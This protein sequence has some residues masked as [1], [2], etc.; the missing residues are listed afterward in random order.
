MR[1]RNP[2]IGFIGFGEAGFH[3]A[4][5]LQTSGAPRLFAYDLHAETAGRGELVQRR[6][7]ASGIALLPTSRALAEASDILISVVTADAA[8]EAAEQTAP[9]L[10]ARHL[11][12]DLNSVSPATKQAISRVVGA[13]TARFVEVAVMA[14]IQENRHRVPML[15]SGTAA[16][17]FMELMAPY[18]MRIERVS[19]EIGSAAA[20]KMCRSII[21][22]G[23]EA[24]VVECAVAANHYNAD[25]RVFASL[26]ESFPGLDWQKLAGYMIGRVVEH[27]ERRAREMEEVA[28][29]L[30]AAGVEPIM[31]EAT[32]RV[33]DWGSNLNL[34]AHTRGELPQT[35]REI[36]TAI[37]GRLQKRASD[38]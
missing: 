19:D 16:L 8:L 28:E 9:Y 18:G 29:T 20:V 4:E 24:L 3:I 25:E 35:Y 15:V 2:I 12:A 31:A 36:I 22:K 26:D 34:L 23:L 37:Q 17:E 32:S 6:A 33:Q 30:R 14:A 38:Q 21:I 13:A 10:N 7:K 1:T 27:G 11:Y 5:G